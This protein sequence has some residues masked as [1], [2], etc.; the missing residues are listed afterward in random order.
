MEG[1]L[2][3]S[4]KYLF[5]VFDGHAG[6]ACA[7]ALKDRLF[8]YMAVSMADGSLLN[9]L[10]QGREN[11]AA[12]LIEYLPTTAKEDISPDLASIHWQS[13]FQFV[14]DSLDM[15]GIDTTV[16]HLIDHSLFK[17][18]NLSLSVKGKNKSSCSSYINNLR[19][20]IN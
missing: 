6:C 5:G 3:G 13:L 16:S 1:K 7:Q 14:N 18:R 4:S 12:Q 15:R 20:N 10:Y 9:K 8:Q 2:A 11:V 19:F 17:D